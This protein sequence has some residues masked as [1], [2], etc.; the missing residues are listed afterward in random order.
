MKP[1][2]KLSGELAINSK[3]KPFQQ[4]RLKLALMYAAGVCVI[5]IAF[6]LAVY[7]VFAKDIAGE[8]GPIEQTPQIEIDR[9]NQIIDTAKARLRT[10]LF[11]ADGLIII[12]TVGLSY[13][14]AG[15]TLRPVE[16]AYEKQKKFVAD[17]AHELRTPLAV[18]KTGA[19]T[20][21]AGKTSKQQLEKLTHESLDEINFL[22][23]TVNDLL[24]L[25]QSDEKQTPVLTEINL[26]D[27]TRRQVILMRPHA[28]QKKITL[29][30]N[31]EADLYINGNEEQLKRLITNLVQNATQYSHSKSKITVSLVKDG[32]QANLTI[33]DNGIGI[34][35]SELK[36]IFDRFYKT[37]RARTE[38]G[39]VGLGLSI[40]R[41]IVSSHK[42]TI[43]I[44]SRIGKDTEVTVFFPLPS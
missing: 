26:S 10:T 30:D 43:T 18:M 7:G 3:S 33:A 22:S 1:T 38:S 16:A 29:E 24:F 31:I 13:W 23:Q 44:K 28:E 36:R 41:E 25:A 20:A 11:V 40:V 27:I 8:V 17:A 19:E 12:I 14:I 32:Q 5:V 39:G 21:L 15:R 37:D 35:A 9:E 2:S 42:G 6:S 34:S 4:A